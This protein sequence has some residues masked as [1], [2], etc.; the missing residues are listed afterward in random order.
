MKFKSKATQDQSHEMETTSRANQDWIKTT[1][2]LDQN[3]TNIKTKS[4][5]N[6]DHM[7][8][9][10]RAALK[11]KSRPTSRPTPRPKP[12]YVKPKSRPAARPGSIRDP[13]STWLRPQGHPLSWK[14]LLRQKLSYATTTSSKAKFPA[15]RL[16]PFHVPLTPPLPPLPERRGLALWNIKGPPKG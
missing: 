1:Y 12:N 14:A 4:I 9:S 15:Q 10:S 6:Q 16:P 3:E 11:T 8:L 7:K 2:S 5:S 13:I